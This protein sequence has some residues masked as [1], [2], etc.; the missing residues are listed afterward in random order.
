M[1]KKI[2][3]INNENDYYDVQDELLD[4]YGDLPRAVQN[5]L[6]IALVKS[7]VHTLGGTSIAQ[8]NGKVLIK[9]RT[10]NSVNAEKTMA[11]V[12]ESKGKIMV[13]SAGG[14][15]TLSYTIKNENNILSEIKDLVKQIM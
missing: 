5:L 11:L 14:D 15:T 6:D 8:R 4:R 2:S 1:Y 13:T 3:L 7:S 12:A 9:F 10:K